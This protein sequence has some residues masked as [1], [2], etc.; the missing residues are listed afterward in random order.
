[1]ANNL[2]TTVITNTN[3][4]AFQTALNAWLAINSKR[5]QQI[6]FN[7]VSKNIVITQYIATIIHFPL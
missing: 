3:L 7:H 1:M 4:L 5:V 6:S 2:V